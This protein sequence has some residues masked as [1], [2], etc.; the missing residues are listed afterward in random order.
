MLL[1]KKW[2]I[3]NWLEK[4]RLP[5]IIYDQLKVRN[6]SGLSNQPNTSIRSL[7]WDVLY[8]AV[9]KYVSELVTPRWKLSPVVF[10]H[11]LTAR[12]TTGLSFQ[13]NISSEHMI[14]YVKDLL[15]PKAGPCQQCSMDLNSTGS[16]IDYV[17][18]MQLVMSK[19]WRKF[20]PSESF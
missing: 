16:S 14:I 15:I 2:T 17:S 11:W 8:K 20:Y 12:N 19:R 6:R 3:H 13:P 18:F 4:N 5:Y 10:Y 7:I 9:W 1:E